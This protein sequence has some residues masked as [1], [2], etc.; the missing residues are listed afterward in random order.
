ML[1]SGR[2]GI[3]PKRVSTACRRII[4]NSM[5]ILGLFLTQSMQEMLSSVLWSGLALL[6]SGALV[7]NSDF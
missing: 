7:F 5:A 6:S 4:Q 2:Y 1:F 3:L